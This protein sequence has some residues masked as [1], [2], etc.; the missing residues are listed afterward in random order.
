MRIRTSLFSTCI[1][2][3]AS[4]PTAT[5]QV[6]RDGASFWLK[7]SAVAVHL[8][9]DGGN[10]LVRQI[11]N[12]KAGNDVNCLR[13]STLRVPL[14]RLDVEDTAGVRTAV[15]LRADQVV[16]AISST[17]DGDDTLVLTWPASSA[18]PVAVTVVCRV[19]RGD[20]LVRMRISVQNGSAMTLSRVD[21]PVIDGIGPLS[22]DPRTDCVIWPRT[23]G[24]LIAN[25]YQT[26]MPSGY[27][28][29]FPYPS[30]SQ[31]M[32]FVGIYGQ[33]G[34]LYLAAQ[35]PRCTLK[36]LQFEKT[37]AQTA[38]RF[39]LRH[40]PENIGKPGNALAMDYD[41]VLTGFTGSWW[42]AAA[43]Y[44]A[45][46]IGQ[47][48]CRQG[49]L[50]DDP[51]VSSRFKTIAAWLTLW[52]APQN[53]ERIA[54]KAHEFFQLPLAGHWYSWHELPPME[55]LFPDPKI[56]DS[57]AAKALLKE[58]DCNLGIPAYFPPKAGFA[59]TI[60][61]LQQQDVR[62]MP[63]I[64]VRIWD[65]TMDSFTLESAARATVKQPNGLTAFE[66]YASQPRP[67]ALMCPAAPSWQDK[68]A[69]TVGTLI[70]RYHTAGVY[71]DQVSA[72]GA[73][74]CHDAT[75]P[76]PSGGGTYWVAGYWQMLDR[77]RE[78]NAGQDYFLTG[79][80][81]TESYVSR[82]EGFLPWISYGPDV[83]PLAQAVYGGKTVFWGRNFERA[84][85]DTGDV[86]SKFADM[87][88]SDVQLGWI[89]HWMLDPK[90]L[91]QMEFV[92]D[93]ARLYDS[94]LGAPFLGGQFVEPPRLL[95]DL[96]PR[97]VT[98]IM[99]GGQRVQVALPAVLV[100]AWKMPENASRL[101]LINP[102]TEDVSFRLDFPHWEG[103]AGRAGPRTIRL[104]ST[105]DCR[106]DTPRR[107]SLADI[108]F[109]LNP[110][111]ASVLEIDDAL[112]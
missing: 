27:W 109:R 8:E 82:V 36:R 83:I 12:V 15:P 99:S 110:R 53:V 43:I 63:Y 93:L 95:G 51:R 79:E 94:A 47:P 5:G 26:G 92:R 33:R 50:A 98:W 111:Q 59:E 13:E 100:A 2:V 18:R 91:P 21:F 75:H 16:S 22:D 77:I 39:Y 66:E 42:Q 101:L 78:Q 41:A 32:Q 86:C 88:T 87:L 48:W 31:S 70:K 102:F 68:M 9:Q 64:N 4:L 7:T 37:E 76:H 52:G 85:M 65:A 97:N 90:Y 54:L 11:R 10:V 74:L 106:P 20:P 104:R 81:F 34:G 6:T 107:I 30:A 72:A 103:S 38:L 24:R 96:P 56:R 28:E 19:R 84:D 62:I 46:A 35:D 67:F 69:D 61:R 57:A 1:L 58:I 40:Y 89:S 60:E 80:S 25:P 44:R 73:V 71:L 49:W 14:W 112:R 55:R 17:P 23:T 45:W 29:E 105:P 108:D 3:S